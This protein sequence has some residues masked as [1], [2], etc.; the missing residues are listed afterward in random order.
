MATKTLKK[1]APAKA[2]KSTGTNPLTD[3]VR[4]LWYAGLGVFSVASQEG[5][6]LI[7]QGSKL[8]DTLVAE[9]SKMEKKSIDLV[10]DTVDEIKS[11]VETRIESFRKQANENWDGLGDVFDIRVSDTLGRLG[12]PTTSDLNNLSGRVQEM[13]QQAKDNWKGFE[14]VFEKR[15]A[16]VLKS[17]RVPSFEDLNKVSEALQ[18]MSSEAQENLGKLDVSIEER[19]SGLFGKLEKNTAEELKKLSS[20]LSEVSD[21]V[22]AN[23]GKLENVIEERVAKIMADF[24][25]PTKDD[26]DKLSMELRKLATQVNALEKQLKAK[27]TAAPKKAAAKKAK[28]VSKK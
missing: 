4:D 12:I 6:K 21:E 14:G 7:G 20:G 1:K 15:V 27:P 3:S 19:V 28:T 25:I 22:S 9:G 13:T 8:F 10:E 17:L 26:T 23:W 5:E 16:D 24:D 11:D 2:A 18:K